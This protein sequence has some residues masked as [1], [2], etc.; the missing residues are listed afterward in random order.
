M[1]NLIGGALQAWRMA[2]DYM[3]DRRHTNAMTR[4]F[5]DVGANERNAI[6]SDLGLSSQDFHEAMQLPYASQDLNAAALESLGVDRAR[7]EARH[8]AWSHE[9]KRTCM[10]CRSR[11]RCLRELTT[12]AFA[13]TYREFCPNGRDLGDLISDPEAAAYMKRPS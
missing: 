1:G 13:S 12:G 6:L 8:G 4:E 3:N 9:I 10:L 7:F 11:R 2:V 5:W